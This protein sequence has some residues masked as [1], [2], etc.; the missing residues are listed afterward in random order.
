MGCEACL[1]LFAAIVCKQSL[2][3]FVLKCIFRKLCRGVEEL[4]VV[5]AV[6]GNRK[7]IVLY[8]VCKDFS[9]VWVDN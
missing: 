4:I 6:G 3:D 9:S 8:L 2:V 1:S 5:A 7:D